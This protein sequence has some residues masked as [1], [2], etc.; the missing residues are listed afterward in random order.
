MAVKTMCEC[1]YGGDDD[2]DDNQGVYK[3]NQANFQISM[4]FQEQVMFALLQ[5][6]SESLHKNL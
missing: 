1:V 3:F 2:D 5:P 6:P 4:R